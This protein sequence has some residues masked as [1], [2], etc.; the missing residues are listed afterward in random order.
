MSL[1][2]VGGASA[3]GP[4]VLQALGLERVSA[5]TIEAAALQEALAAGTVHIRS[6]IVLICWYMSRM[7]TSF[8]KSCVG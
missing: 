5:S 4:Q 1:D 6:R 8:T 2:E 3:K 7:C